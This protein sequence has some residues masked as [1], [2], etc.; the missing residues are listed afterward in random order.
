MPDELSPAH[1]NFNPVTPEAEA[2][3]CAKAASRCFSLRCDRHKVLTWE[4]M[5]ASCYL[6]L[7]AALKR[8]KNESCTKSSARSRGEARRGRS[9]L[10]RAVL[11]VRVRQNGEAYIGLKGKTLEAYA[12]FTPDA[13]ATPKRGVKAS[14]CFSESVAEGG[15]GGADG[16]FLIYSS[17]SLFVPKTIHRQNSRWRNGSRA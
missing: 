15:T 17:T 11:S 7:G 2:P 16:P 5:G 8:P 13:E 12:G 3:R 4:W 14:V 1:N 6:R 9:T 10:E